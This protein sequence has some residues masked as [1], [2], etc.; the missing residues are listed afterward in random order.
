LKTL[1]THRKRKISSAGAKGSSGPQ[2]GPFSQG[3]AKG[4]SPTADSLISGV[5]LEIPVPRIYESAVAIVISAPFCDN[6]RNT[7]GCNP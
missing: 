5:G 3:N 7:R 6:G 4:I 1:K 2:F